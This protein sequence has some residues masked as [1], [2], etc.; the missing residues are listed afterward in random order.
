MLVYYAHPMSWYDTESERRDLAVLSAHY[1][2]AT[3][4][5]PNSEHFRLLVEQA[6]QSNKTSMAPFID[7]I[8]RERPLVAYRRFLDG[9]IGAGVAKEVMEGLAQGG[10]AVELVNKGGQT[11]IDEFGVS[12][13]IFH[14][15]LSIE[16]TRE[17]NKR[18]KL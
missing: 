9:T 16:Q 1:E 11:W 6:K 15:I 18:G 7:F 12:R 8:A 4:I 5:N 17:R 14:D 10:G 13:T 3:I 2:G